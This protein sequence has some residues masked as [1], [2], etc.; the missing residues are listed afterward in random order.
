MLSKFKRSAC[1][2]MNAFVTAFDMTTYTYA[3]AQLSAFCTELSV[4]QKS[5]DLDWMT[6]NL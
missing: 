2:A 3:V 5:R 6:M 1:Q 4:V